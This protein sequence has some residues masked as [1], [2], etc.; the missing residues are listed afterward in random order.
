MLPHANLSFVTGK[1]VRAKL[2]RF[3]LVWQELSRITVHAV[4]PAIRG[5]F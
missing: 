5:E 2:A 3:S 1:S 4:S